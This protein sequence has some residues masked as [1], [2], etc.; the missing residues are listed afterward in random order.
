MIEQSHVTSVY[1]KKQVAAFH[2][3]MLH[4]IHMDALSYLKSKIPV[5]DIVFLD[6]PFGKPQLLLESIRCLESS[7]SFSPGG[8]LYTESSQALTLDL[9]Q[10]ETLKHKKAGHILYSLYK[11]RDNTPCISTL[12]DQDA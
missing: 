8:L 3:N 4:V 11:K 12:S 10:W 7:P 6:P 9:N 5:F 1:L 2:S